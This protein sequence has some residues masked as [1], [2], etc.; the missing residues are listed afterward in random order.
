[1][2]RQRGG[3]ETALR[4]LAADKRSTYARN[5]VRIPM[6]GHEVERVILQR[7]SF[8]AR[9][10]RDAIQSP[11]YCGVMWA[12]DSR[13]A[14]LPDHSFDAPYA[15]LTSRLTPDKLLIMSDRDGFCLLDRHGVL[16][17]V[18]TWADTRINKPGEWVQHMQALTR[19]ESGLFPALAARVRRRCSDAILALLCISSRHC[20]QRD[21]WNALVVMPVW[22]TRA[23]EDVWPDEF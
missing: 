2:K 23:A 5:D 18:P 4:T 6:E 8:D 20:A 16:V 14:S 9:G 12:V 1:M 17:S 21:M 15:P 22:K 7:D 19:I 11:Y 13:P 3:W 10:M